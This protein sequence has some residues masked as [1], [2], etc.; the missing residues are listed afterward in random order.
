MNVYTS[1]GF[2]GHYPVGTAAVVVAKNAEIAAAILQDALRREG[3]DQSINSEDMK[4][5]ETENSLVVILNDG[6]Y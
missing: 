5:L 6:N 3:L 1:K 2:E 4:E